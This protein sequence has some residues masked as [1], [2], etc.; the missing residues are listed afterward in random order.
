MKCA[1][2]GHRETRGLIPKAMFKELDRLIEQGVDTFYCG[3][4][5]GFDLLA[6]EHLIGKAKVIACVP[7]PDQ[8]QKFDW[9]ERGRYERDLAKCDEQV[10]I[11]PAY[12]EDCYKKRNY[13]MVDHADIVY[14]FFNGKQRSGTAQTIR[15]AKKKGLEVIIH[16]PHTPLDD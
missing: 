6:C 10:I 15:Y 1:L 5:Q 3:M 11:C 4:A 9:Y 2:T 14:A 13:Y 16:D 8:A 12:E 7:Y